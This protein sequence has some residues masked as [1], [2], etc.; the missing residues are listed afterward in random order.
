MK[1]VDTNI[2]LRLFVRDDD[3]Q[4]QRSLRVLEA[5]TADGE[6]LFVSHVVLVEL[7]WSLRSAYRYSLQQIDMVVVSILN[8][9]AFVVQQRDRVVAALDMPSTGVGL[10]DR[11]IASINTD[12]GCI[13]TLTYDRRAGRF[14]TFEHVE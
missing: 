11:L 14:S 10:A 3:E 9:D 8:S 1:G 7:C 6:A 12:E 2:L 13:T 4:H 5:A